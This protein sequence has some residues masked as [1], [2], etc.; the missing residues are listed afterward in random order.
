[1]SHQYLQD[2]CNDDVNVTD[3]QYTNTHTHT[4]THKCL[5]RHRDWQQYP[6][7]CTVPHC[8]TRWV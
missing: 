7:S 4:H 1:M 8:V 3:K 2:I 5:H 6:A